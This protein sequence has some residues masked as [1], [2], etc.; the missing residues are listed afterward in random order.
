[1]TTPPPGSAHTGRHVN[2][3]RPCAGCGFN[4][5]GQ[6]IVREPHYQ[7]L[8]TRCPECGRMVALQEYPALGR[9]AGRWAAVLA[10]AWAA[11]LVLAMLVMVGATRL[12]IELHAEHAAL[13]LAQQIAD[14]SAVHLDR[15]AT[16]MGT[17]VWMPVDFDWWGANGDRIF[18]DYGG[19]ARAFRDAVWIGW[20][21]IG[22]FW[23]AAGAFW[24]IATL[25]ARR[26]WAAAAALAPVA[27]GVALGWAARGGVFVLQAT[28][29]AAA[30]ELTR[31]AG[32]VTAALLAFAGII[33]GVW[34]GRRF[35]RW[36]VRVTLPPRARAPLA[37]L[38]TR[39]GLPP[40]APRSV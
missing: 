39:D 19:H 23:F 29:Q 34:L 15:T 16:P 32:V 22:V 7:M 35:A 33:L 10:A 26:R 21:P 38:W 6:P 30:A 28:A 13:P 9:W 40:P 17:S 24:S 11:G 3:D 14:A 25:G 37:I 2:A 18:A 8:A 27:V 4:L 31:P 36:L 5:H 20:I 12:M 1:M